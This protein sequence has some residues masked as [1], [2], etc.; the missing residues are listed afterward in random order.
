M[1]FELGEF[2]QTQ[3]PKYYL[4][5]NPRFVE[6]LK[7]YYQWLYRKDGMSEDELNNVQQN[8]SKWSSINIDKFIDTES[9]RYNLYS[10]SEQDIISEIA[11]WRAPGAIIERFHNQYLLQREYDAFV[12]ADGDYF[13]DKNDNGYDTSN[14]MER[15]VDIWA[16]KFKHVRFK[17]SKEDN[18][19]DELLLIRSMKMLYAAK[20]SEQCVK[21]FFKVYFNEDIEVYIPKFDMVVID[22][23]IENIDT[24]QHIRD[25]KYYQEFAYVIRT[26]NPP[27]N[28]KEM[29]ENIYLKDFHPGGFAVFLEQKE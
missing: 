11:H 12:T 5:E 26:E 24:D 19:Y 1:L 2:V 17:D 8:I 18:P 4:D 29:F 28:Y 9:V 10:G 23:E 16:S 6:L 22:G 3:V 7:N 13:F 25:D 20:G 15:A 14:M 21:L 27:E